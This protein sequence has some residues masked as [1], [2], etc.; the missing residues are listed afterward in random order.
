MG[1]SDMTDLQI[2]PEQLQRQ[3][4]SPT[5][6]VPMFA[7]PIAWWT[8]Q[9]EKLSYSQKKNLMKAINQEWLNRQLRYLNLAD[10]T[11]LQ[12]EIDKRFKNE[13]E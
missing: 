11:A 12:I 10:L 9:Y 3:Q 5:G 2:D 7:Q 8:N 13:K 1:Q 6:T 4:P